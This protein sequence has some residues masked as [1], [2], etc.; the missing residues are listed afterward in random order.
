VLRRHSSRIARL[1]RS[2]LGQRLAGAMAYGRIA[3]YF[4]PQR[5]PQGDERDLDDGKV[6][7]ECRKNVLHPPQKRK[8]PLGEGGLSRCFYWWWVGDPKLNAVYE[9]PTKLD[10]C[11]CI[12]LTIAVF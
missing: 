1:D 3:G 4:G 8:S 9:L 6:A 7:A 12:L 5:V 11:S 2:V 10:V